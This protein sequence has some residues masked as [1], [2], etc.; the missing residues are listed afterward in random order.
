MA[1]IMKSINTDIPYVSIKKNIK[2]P[3]NGR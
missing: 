2:Y 3:I 1:S